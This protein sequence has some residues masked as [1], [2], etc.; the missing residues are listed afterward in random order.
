MADPH[1]VEE[2]PKWDNVQP[3]RDDEQTKKD[4]FWFWVGVM[5]IG[6]LIFAYLTDIFP[7]SC[8]WCED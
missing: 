8:P 1:M 2:Q 5:V 3:K 4:E 6:F 7:V